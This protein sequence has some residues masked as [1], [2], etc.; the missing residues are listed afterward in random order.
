[1]VGEEANC[2]Q[3]NLGMLNNGSFLRKGREGCTLD[4]LIQNTNQYSSNTDI[5][6]VYRYQNN[7][8]TLIVNGVTYTSSNT[9]FTPSYFFGIGMGNNGRMKNILI[10]PL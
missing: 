4:Y 10:K 2:Q 6:V 3:Y 7:T 1:M 8:H 5:S 9:D